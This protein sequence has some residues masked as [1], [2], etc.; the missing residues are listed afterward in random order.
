ME[1]GDGGRIKTVVYSSVVADLFH[2]GHLQLLEYAKS[3]GDYHICGVITDEAVESYRRKP[4]ANLQERK[5]IISSLNCVDEVIIQ[6]NVNPTGNLRKIRERYGDAELIVV[7]GSD[8]RDIPWADSIEQLGCRIVQHPYY[9]RLSDFKIIDRLMKSYKGK[10]KDF[11]DFTS[12]FKVKG[13]IEFNHKEI[14]KTLIST[15]ADT[16]KA[17]Q[18]LLKHS[19]IE[20]TLVFTVMDWNEKREEILLRIKKEFTPNKIV[21]RSS[22][23]NEDTL[24]SSM[25][26]CFDSILNVSPDDSVKVKESINWII[27]SYK[28]LNLNNL[29]NQILIQLQTRDI[30]ISGV[31]FTRTLDSNAPYYVINYDDHTGLSDTVTRGVENKTIRILKGIDERDYPDKFSG[32]LTA[33]H[34]IEEIIPDIGLDIEFAIDRRGEVSIFQVRPMT[35]NTEINKGD[36]DELMNRIKAMQKRFTELS[37]ERSHIVGGRNYFGDMPDWNPA[38]IIGNNPNYLDYSLYA[39]IIMDSIWHEAR[40]SQGYIN[41]APAR[42]MA[43]FGNK[44]YVDIRNTFNSFIPATTSKK[45]HKKLISFYM[46]KL[47]S[48]PELQ[49]KVEFEILYTCYDFS[50]DSRS[51]ELLDYGFTVDEIDELKASLLQLTNNLIKN[52]GK[53]IEEDINAAHEMRKVRDEVDEIIKRNHNSP[54]DMIKQTH[55]LL[56]DCRIHG[57]LP[58]SRLA[59]LAFIGKILLKSLA[60]E[61]VINKEFYNSFQNSVNTVASEISND[62]SRYRRGELSREE[63]LEKYGHLRPGTYDITSPRY[64]ANPELLKDGSTPAPH[65]AE[66]QKTDFQIDDEIH[67]RIDEVLREHAMEFNSRELFMFIKSSLE[68]REYSKFE[69]T[70]SLSDAIELIAR[71]GELLGF[72]REELAQLDV[73]SIFLCEKENI[74]HT[75]DIWRNII[76][77][78]NHERI[79]DEKIQLPPIIFS[80]KDFEIIS[81]Y[82]A[83]PNFITHKKAEGETV[84]LG[85]VEQDIDL[86]EKIVLIESGDPGYDW[87]FTRNIAG[88]ITEYGGI[89]S[90]MAI[91]C[92]EFEIPAA[93]G[94][95]KVIFNN[96]KKAPAII[97]DCGQGRITQV[98]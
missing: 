57:T 69:F 51:K 86:N 18:P 20:K 67:D 77:S 43:R 6:D 22:A 55:R 44:P 15:K 49:D 27:D 5:A 98:L 34:E 70:K 10:F 84:N 64:D 17:L 79:L 52:S 21:V 32:L 8:W 50:F 82:S 60:S 11:K 71:A 48:N 3:L 36:D 90:H 9:E 46:D 39:H 42:L 16:L 26:G 56:D 41:V 45:L 35:L 2:Y 30:E 66:D 73:E 96:L 74:K 92:A 38:E 80:E 62:F 14:K 95:G 89:A 1:G 40:S 68:A 23:I 13:F 93:I 37:E 19:R 24:D 61:G 85:D 53:T 87:I 29:F 78:R 7:Y 58:F 94:C 76:E 12:Y 47:R 72:T 75:Q 31:L 33:V 97:L 83:R 63:F 28:K 25:A 59:R 88:L 4:V 91:R 81:Y 54:R 65:A